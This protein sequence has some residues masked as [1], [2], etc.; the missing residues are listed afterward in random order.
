M[1]NLKISLQIL[2]IGLLALVGFVAIGLIYFSSSSQQAE[3]L[4]TQLSEAQGVEYINEIKIGFLEE[5]RNEKDF[6]VRQDMKYAEQHKA[7]AEEIMPYFDKLKT[8]H[9]AHR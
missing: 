8:I 6:I 2:L 9:Q 5:R 1:K 7:K 4:D 3:Y